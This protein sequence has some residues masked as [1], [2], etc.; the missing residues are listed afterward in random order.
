MLYLEQEYSRQF[1]CVRV[2]SRVEC[3]RVRTHLKKKD[4]HKNESNRVRPRPNSDIKQQISNGVLYTTNFF[5][6]V[7]FIILYFALS[8]LHHVSG[9]KLILVIFEGLIIIIFK[10]AKSHK[11]R[12][13]C[14]SMVLFVQS[15]AAVAVCS[16]CSAV[17]PIT[18]SGIGFVHATVTSTICN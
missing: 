15:T 4:E 6:H 2:H 18:S 5:T 3:S 9:K 13:V 14:K 12:L 11:I 10:C 16:Y 8:K 17:L 1:V 7:F